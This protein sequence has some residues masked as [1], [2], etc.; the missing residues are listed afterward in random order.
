[1]INAIKYLP[2]KLK[3]GPKSP[4]SIGPNY[5]PSQSSKFVYDG[6][7]FTFSA[8]RHS[9]RSRAASDY[10]DTKNSELSGYPFR[11]IIGSADQNTNWEQM[12]CFARSWCYWG[13]WFTG[14]QIELSL[15]VFITRPTEP[16]KQDLS[17]FNPKFFEG[18]IPEILTERYGHQTGIDHLSAYQAPVDWKVVNRH[19]VPA[20]IYWVEPVG[21]GFSAPLRQQL[22]FPVSRGAL[23]IFS[24]GFD[25]YKP[26][27][28]KNR[29]KLV[30]LAKP[31]ALVEEIIQSLKITLSPQAQADLDK[32]KAE[33]PGA[34]LTETFAPLKW[35]V[36]SEDLNLNTNEHAISQT[37]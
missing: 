25:I 34:K 18:Y 21:R 9:P 31:K 19:P 3:D 6:S 27:D 32:A 11:Q 14:A 13:P 28:N 15:N 29:L 1:M 12:K 26:G 20:A 4:L 10:T 22:I 2:F 16:L 33:C 30:N 37:Q 17:L 36:N 8:P 7:L 23:A 24:F 5:R 35:P